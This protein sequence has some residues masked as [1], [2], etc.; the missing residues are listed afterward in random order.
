MSSYQSKESKTE[1]LQTPLPFVAKIKQLE[2]F[3]GGA[4]EESDEAL[5]QRAVMSVHRFSTAG[6]EKGYIYHGLS[7]SAKNSF[8]KSFK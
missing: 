2:F 3:S 6:S 4:S 5:R 8:Y 1:F 7:A